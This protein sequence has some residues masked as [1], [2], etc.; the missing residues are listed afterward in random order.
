M[1]LWVALCMLALVA[2]T[3]SK[4]Y[5]T[6]NPTFSSTAIHEIKEAL[7]SSGEFNIEGFVVEKSECPPCPTP[8]TCAPC[9]PETITISELNRPATDSLQNSDMVVFAD[10]PDQFTV[11]RRYRFSILITERRTV[12]ERF[13]DVELVGYS[14]ITT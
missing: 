3:G 7:L 4:T 14:S 11:G 8:G 1:K 9:P 6:V 13:N 10:K 2:C 12:E 5:P